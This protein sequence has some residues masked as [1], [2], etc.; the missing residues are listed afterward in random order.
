MPTM[1]SNWMWET[2]SVQSG[3][4]FTLYG[5]AIKCISETIENLC[6]TAIDNDVEF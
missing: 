6:D 2:P 3:G 5:E 1:E 4:M